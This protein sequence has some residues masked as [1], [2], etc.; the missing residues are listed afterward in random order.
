MCLT[1]VVLTNEVLQG[2]G[3]GDRM[4]DVISA[5]SLNGSLLRMCMLNV[6]CCSVRIRVGGGTRFE[7]WQNSLCV[8]QL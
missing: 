8:W 3:F 2:V 7:R 4:D 6:F 5:P 1:T